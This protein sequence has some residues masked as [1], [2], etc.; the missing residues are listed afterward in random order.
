MIQQSLSTW[1]I[2]NLKLIICLSIKMIYECIIHEWL[3]IDV[4]VLNVDIFS[5]YSSFVL[6]EYVVPWFL[7]TI[8]LP[9]FRCNIHVY[10]QG[11]ITLVFLD[12]PR[13]TWKAISRQVNIVYRFPF[14]IHGK[15]RN[16]ALIIRKTKYGQTCFSY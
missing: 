15:K 1:Y 4:Q 8:S 2:R 13:E 6:T 5:C 11:T 16:T 14:I 7:C 9:L 12:N 3:F 10:N